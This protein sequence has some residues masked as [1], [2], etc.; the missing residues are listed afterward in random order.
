MSIDQV[1]T[2]KIASEILSS[3]MVIGEKYG[4]SIRVKET[5]CNGSAMAMQLVGTSSLKKADIKKEVFI[6]PSKNYVD[7]FVDVCESIGLNKGHIGSS[8]RD[9]GMEY[10]ILGYD[11]TDKKTPIITEDEFG[12]T[13]KFSLTRPVIMGLMN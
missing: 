10:T 4:V 1:L 8:F 3:A 6:D 5:Q 13:K 12:M 9:R 2:D 11:V 7:Q